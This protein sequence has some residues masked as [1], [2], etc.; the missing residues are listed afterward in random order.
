MPIISTGETNNSY[1]YAGEQYDENL[2]GYYLRQR[3][4]NP[5]IGRFVSQ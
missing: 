1:R 5:S 4:Y 2:D 3:Y